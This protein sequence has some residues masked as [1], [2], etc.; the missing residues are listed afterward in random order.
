MPV[1]LPV[2]RLKKLRD[3]NPFFCQPWEDHFV[4][5]SDVKRALDAGRLISASTDRDH[6]GRIAYLVL[7]EATDPVHIDAGIPAMN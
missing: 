1:N 2:N 6:A 7:H 3:F 4:Q 5:K